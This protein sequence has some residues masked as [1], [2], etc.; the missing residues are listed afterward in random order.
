MKI[1]VTWYVA[2]LLMA[3]LSFEPQAQG[4][5]ATIFDGAHSGNPDFFFLPPLVGNP[6]SH[7]F[8]DEGTFDPALSP[9]VEICFIENNKCSAN[10]PVGFPLIS[11]SSIEFD[12]VRISEGDELYIT[13]WHVDKSG[14][15]TGTY[16]IFV[17]VDDVL[18]GFTDI[19]LLST[20]QEAK[21]LDSGETFVLAGGALPIK[22]RIERSAFEWR[23]AQPKGG[24]LQFGSDVI[25][26]IPEG[27]LSQYAAI[28]LGPLPLS[29]VQLLLDEKEYRSSA[30][31]VLSGFSAEP[32]GLL[33]SKPVVVTLAIPAPAGVPMQAEVDL[34][35]QEYW[36]AP[37]NLVFDPA[38][39]KASFPL[40]HF[41]NHIIVDLTDLATRGESYEVPEWCAEVG[42]RSVSLEG[43]WSRHDGCQIVQSEV[44]MEFPACDIT[45]I[46]HVSETSPECDE[47]F[48][49]IP[50][51]HP[52][53]LRQCRSETLMATVKDQD[54]KAWEVP[55][56]WS[57]GDPSILAVHP[58]TGDATGMGEGTVLVTV[59]TPDPRF[60]G[61]E[62]LG[63]FGLPP[64]F[65][66]PV[67]SS[68]EVNETILLKALDEVGKEYMCD[69]RSPNGLEFTRQPATWSV[70]D[71]S[72]VDVDPQ[73]GLVTGMSP[74]TATVIAMSGFANSSAIVEVT[75]APPEPPGNCDMSMVVVYTEL[76]GWPGGTGRLHEM[77]HAI[78]LQPGWSLQY[79]VLAEDWSVE[80]AVSAIPRCLSN[81]WTWT[82]LNESI[83]TV[84]QTGRVTAHS[85]GMAYFK[86]IHVR[87]PSISAWAAVNVVED[88]LDTFFVGQ[89]D[90]EFSYSGV[91]CGGGPD[92][93]VCD[94]R[95]LHEEVN[96][97]LGPP[98]LFACPPKYLPPFTTWT[99]HTFR[100]PYTDPNR[101]CEVTGGYSND[102]LGK[103]DCIGTLVDISE[104]WGD[105]PPPWSEW[106]KIYR[107]E[108]A[109]Q[110]W[111]VGQ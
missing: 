71:V 60:T 67:D 19:L 54:N 6:N 59:R 51:I 109:M 25:F 90:A 20:R 38:T 35:A 49:L 39:G 11:G 91:S 3:L 13:N 46:Q 55:V 65:I 10:Q 72:V 1:N 73:V 82:S 50:L 21:N 45:T 96:K 62:L 52:V 36:L 83:A 32:D 17:V 14:S 107:D 7:P 84:D 43:S 42:Y 37:T 88:W 98:L 12:N 76:A 58:A 30:K 34:E 64:L 8:F 106:T 53:T 78:T 63:V 97:G 87:H 56:W 48:Q 105:E 101:D 68:I 108:S 41:S 5:N 104:Y 81:E 29:V 102:D 74:G 15:A 111:W 80:P 23:I 22:F 27:A 100:N 95:K 92:G 24:I 86:V 75:E 2:G 89:P 9:R 110:N 31:T 47:D 44:K 85:V 99:C 18:L 93:Y 66:E 40:T 4:L 77:S 79:D 61:T 16:R 70:A 69:T 94:H 57:S 33:F 103:P 28:R 26:D